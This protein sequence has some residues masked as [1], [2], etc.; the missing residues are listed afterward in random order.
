[1]KNPQKPTL[2]PC[3]PSDDFLNFLRGCRV[4]SNLKSSA[5]NRTMSMNEPRSATI[6]RRA[7]LLGTVCITFAATLLADNIMI[8]EDN[9][10]ELKC[11]L[12]NDRFRLV[13]SNAPG[14]VFVGDERVDLRMAFK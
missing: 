13:G 10:K 4:G 3:R 11:S 6:G 2:R 9:M 14:Q 1:M 8:Q 7:L 5:E 12:P